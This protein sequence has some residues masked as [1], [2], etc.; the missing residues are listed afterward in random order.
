MTTD[1]IH[2]YIRQGNVYVLS[3]IQYSQQIA[4][5]FYVKYGK[6]L[7]N[8]GIEKHDVVRINKNRY[9]VLSTLRNYSSVILYYS[10]TP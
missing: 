10:K 4:L 3:D 1:S 7:S 8:Q 5:T 9:R 2:T 6:I